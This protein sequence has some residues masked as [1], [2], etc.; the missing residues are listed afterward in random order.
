MKLT[1]DCQNISN[2]YNVVVVVIVV[3]FCWGHMEYGAC[4]G[5]GLNISSIKSSFRSSNNSIFYMIFLTVHFF[6]SKCTVLLSVSI[7]SKLFD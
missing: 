2:I 5:V 6:L 3:V 1:T 7:M 4:F